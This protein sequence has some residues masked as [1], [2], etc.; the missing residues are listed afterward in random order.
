MNLEKYLEG[1]GEGR[2]E[3]GRGGEKGKEGGER[4]K[5]ING[6]KE[7]KSTHTLSPS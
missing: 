1:E 5:E 7:K 6:M 4:D 3:G 2:I